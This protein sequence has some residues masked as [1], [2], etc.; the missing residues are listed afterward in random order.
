M[1]GM[2]QKDSYVGDEARFGTTLSTVRKHPVLLRAE[3]K[4]QEQRALFEQALHDAGCLMLGLP[5]NLVVLKK[6]RTMHF[7]CSRLDTMHLL[8]C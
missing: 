8:L 3:G 5:S 4:V 6:K 2:D 7:V 1:V